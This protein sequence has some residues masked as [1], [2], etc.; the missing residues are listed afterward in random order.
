MR[1]T[2]R[3]IALAD[4]V[5]IS[6]AA[7]TAG[8]FHTM[9]SAQTTT[10]PQTQ[11]LP[12]IKVETSRAKRKPTTKSSTPAKGAAP[13]KTE[14]TTTVA[15]KTEEPVITLAAVSVLRKDDISVAEPGRLSDI[16]TG[17]PGVWF[18]ERGDDPAASI[19][20]RGLQD[21]GRVATLV[22]GAPQN[23][24]RSGHFA[25]G[26]FYVDP[27]MLGG[28]DV[29]RGPVAN[30]Y[31][32]GAIGGVASFR[33]KDLGDILLPGEI[34]AIQTTGMYSTNGNQWL[35]STFMGA[36]SGAT[37]ILPAACSAVVKTTGKVTA[38]SSPTPDRKSN[39]AW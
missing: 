1:R 33:T 23:F 4:A 34:A 6:L 5:H 20:I 15:T 39:P 21:F 9:A 8:A 11:P 17:I 38:Q 25:N 28:V 10:Q 14:P 31:G 7:S 3:R 27:K 16:I 18:S 35:T 26:L 24:Q 29:V 2:K 22:D 12:P 30:I 36:R 32:S 19:N 37:D 13:P